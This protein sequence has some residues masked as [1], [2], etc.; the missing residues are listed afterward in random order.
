MS[1][2]ATMRGKTAKGN[3]RGSGYAR[4]DRDLYV[5]PEWAVEALFDA[6]TIPGPIWDPACG[7]GTVLRVARRRGVE[8]YG[9]DIAEGHDFLWTPH[10]HTAVGGTKMASIV[11]N[12]PFGLAE[13]FIRCALGMQTEVNAFLLRLAFLEGAGR[14][15]RLFGPTPPASVW[16]FSRRVSMPPPDHLIDGRK[17]GG[18]SVAFAWFVWRKRH[19]GPPMIGW[20]P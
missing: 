2:L 7:T 6:E 3:P 17:A 15:E 14:R 12:P 13:K 19:N 9:T 10:V 5:E 16:V 18:G 20:L 1:A 8:A 4:S 11:C